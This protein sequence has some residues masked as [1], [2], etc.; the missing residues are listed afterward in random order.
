MKKIVAVFL[1]ISLIVCLLGGCSEGKVTE[2]R[3]LTIENSAGIAIADM[4]EQ[5][6]NTKKGNV[7]LPVT[8]NLVSRVNGMFMDDECDVAVIPADAAAVLYRKRGGLKVIAGV[9]SGGF[10]ILSNNG[11]L[12]SISDLKGKEIF[13]TERDKLSENLLE[14]VLSKNNIEKSDVVI[15]YSTNVKHIIKDFNANTVNYALLDAAGTA[16]VKA[17]IGNIKSINLTDEWNK[18]SNKQMVNYCV[19]TTDEFLN[20]NKKAIDRLI[21]DI[22]SSVKAA[23]DTKKTGDLAIERKLITDVNYASDIINTSKLKFIKGKE[24]K[25]TLSDYYGVL[26]GIKPFLVGNELPADDFYYGAK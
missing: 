7:Y 26:K 1:V 11:E 22:E 9:S 13:L 17:A 20:K 18:V 24:L 25:T 19:V 5:Y 2:I 4:L 14:Y 6:A 3:V 8:V 12:Q 21:T 23:S 16:E 15:S 10:E